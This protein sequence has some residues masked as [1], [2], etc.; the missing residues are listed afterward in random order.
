MADRRKSLGDAG[1]AAA[2]AFL[3]RQRFRILE[4]NYRCPVGEVDLIGLDAG[5]LVFIEVKT[6]RQDA[7]GSP[8]DAVDARK[9][10]QIER[11]ALHYMTARRLH[12]HAARFD[13][14][15]VTWAGETPQCELIRGAFDA[16]RW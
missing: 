14:V 5:T 10:Q 16:R 4:R 11:A 6:R 8:F 15:G 2:A 7:Y 13:V 12:G 1:E 9:Q 3:E